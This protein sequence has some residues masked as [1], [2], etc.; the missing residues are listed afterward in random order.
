MAQIKLFEL[1]G[2]TRM[3]GEANLNEVPRGEESGWQRLTIAIDSGAAEYVIPTGHVRGWEV[4]APPEPDWFQ[5]ATGEPME[6]KGS[7]TLPLLPD[8]GN[9]RAMTFQNTNVT[10]ALGSVKRICDAGHAVI[11]LPE[12][13]GLSAILNLSTGEVDVLREDE[14]NSMLDAWVPPPDSPAGSA[15]QP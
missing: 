10:K 13:M 2:L 8:A 1:G 15:G 3:R 12:S 7:Q 6:N 4:T 5:S 11:F 14:G 9:L